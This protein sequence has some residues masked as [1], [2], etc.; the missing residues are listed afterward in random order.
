MMKNAIRIIGIPVDLGQSNRGVDMGP[1]AIRYA[2]LLQNL[3]KLGYKVKDEGN[4]EVPVRDSL[5]EKN[6]LPEIRKVCTAS[7]K[8]AARAIDDGCKPVFLGGD[9]SISMG[10][11]GG[12]THKTK[13]GVIW[14]D[15]HGDY[16]TPETS[17]TGN[18]HGMSLAVL[19]G[20]GLPELVNIGRKGPKL[21]P[22][23][24]VLIGVRELDLNEKNLL[25]ESG[26]TIYTM[27]DIDEQGIN[28]IA[29]SALEKL[30]H[31][32][33]IHVSFDI[34][35]L[36]PMEAPGVGTPVPGGLTFREAH[37]L[38]EIIA[39]SKRVSSMDIVEINPIIDTRNQAAQIAVALAQSL[40]GKSIL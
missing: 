8:A 17:N 12:V 16:N 38:M 27:R 33:G 14:I 32:P 37:L 35:S 40:F 9:H 24:V 1:S 28:V 21:N 19:T 34:D 6:L 26:I 39:D 3:R 25:K 10:T 31:L 5:A 36:D 4:I 29:R 2:G 7:Y 20:L 22:E 23:D 15:A 30:S 18:Y 11:I 13:S